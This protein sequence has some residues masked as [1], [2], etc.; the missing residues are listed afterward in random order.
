MRKIQLP[1]VVMT[2]KRPLTTV[3]TVTPQ[4]VLYVILFSIFMIME[5][6]F[7]LVLTLI[8]LVRASY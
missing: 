4:Y 8:F 2:V 5:S 6:V 1:K 3:S 7:F